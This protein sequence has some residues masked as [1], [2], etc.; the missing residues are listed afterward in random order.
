MTTLCPL[1]I[2]PVHEHTA[3]VLRALA[4]IA[5]RH[6]LLPG[7]Y[8]TIEQTEPRFRKETQTWVIEY[9]LIPTPP[10]QEDR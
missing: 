8:Y 4:E 1:L 7:W 9:T 5:E 6:P 10:P 2:T 3:R